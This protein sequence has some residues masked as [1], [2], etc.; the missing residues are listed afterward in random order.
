M[1]L[2]AFR[3]RPFEHTHENRAFND[4]FDALQLHCI[5]TKQDWYLLGN[6]FVG[7]RELDAMVIKPNALNWLNDFGHLNRA[8]RWR[9]NPRCYGHAYFLL[10][11][12][13]T[14]SSGHGAGR[15]TIGP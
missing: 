11:R 13:Q 10:E 6:F 7:S 12:I 5:A 3:G 1:A 9:P 8:L 15:G 4:L 14:Q 2:K